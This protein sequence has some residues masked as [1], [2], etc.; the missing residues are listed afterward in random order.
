MPDSTNVKQSMIDTRQD[1]ELSPAEVRTQAQRD[2][3]LCAAQCCFVRGGFHNAPMAAIAEK[4]GMS[5]GLIYRYFA[6]KNQIILAIIERQLELARSKIRQ[7]HSRTNLSTN[8][9]DYFDAQDAD[10]E[11]S[12]SAALFLEMSAEARRDREIAE[13]VHAFD[14]MVRTELA[15]WL[16]RSIDEGGYALPP[17]IARQRALSLVF[18]IEGLKVR[19]SREPGIDRELLKKSLEQLVTPII[20]GI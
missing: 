17:H 13:A 20:A 3:I 2:R 19:K 9:V 15:D 11:D 14:Q 7:L 8:L 5:P 12:M 10:D 4:A 18:I 6:S 1:E 16:S